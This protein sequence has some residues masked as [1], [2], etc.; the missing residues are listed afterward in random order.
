MDMII[1][2]I[3]LSH[4]K[5]NKEKESLSYIVAIKNLVIVL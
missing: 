5:E 4:N 3:L 2:T 1:I